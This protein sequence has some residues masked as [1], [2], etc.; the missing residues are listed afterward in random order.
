MQICSQHHE[1]CWSITAARTALLTDRECTVIVTERAACARAAQ[2]PRFPACRI[3]RHENAAPPEPERVFA[4]PGDPL[5]RAS[6]G[7]LRDRLQ[8][9]GT[10]EPRTRHDHVYSAY[11]GAC[12]LKQ[13]SHAFIA[14]AISPAYLLLEVNLLM[15]RQFVPFCIQQSPDCIYRIRSVVGY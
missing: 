14:R 2:R 13:T 7:R 8:H 12:G 3:Q 1:Q 9:P 11:N 5:H 15:I 6:A 4:Q 10:R